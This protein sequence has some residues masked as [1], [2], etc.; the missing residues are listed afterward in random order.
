[1]KTNFINAESK[2]FKSGDNGYMVFIQ[3]APEELSRKMYFRSTLKAMR[4]CFILK[5]QQGLEIN[6]EAL[7]LL[8]QAYK[9]EKAKAEVE[10]PETVAAEPVPA[11]PEA[12]ADTAETQPAPEPKKRRGRPS[13]KQKEQQEAA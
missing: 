5:R 4:Y 6:D 13:K 3:G 10:N 12:P 7:A 9:E 1:M 11:A 8:S 2:T